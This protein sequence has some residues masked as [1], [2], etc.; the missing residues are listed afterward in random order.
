MLWIFGAP[1][2]RIILTLLAVCSL[3]ACSFSVPSRDEQSKL[4]QDKVIAGAPVWFANAG[5]GTGAVAQNGIIPST[6]QPLPSLEGRTVDVQYPMLVRAE[7]ISKA[8]ETKPVVT[9]KSALDRIAEQCSGSENEVN[10]AL[11][12]VD[13]DAKIKQYEALTKKCP[14]SADLQLWLSNEY[15]KANKLVAARTGYGQV[16]VLDPTNEDAKI[17]ISKVEKALS[18]QQ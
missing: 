8:Q 1:L 9:P 4:V 17:G 7:E 16:L 5:A 12:N 11:T 3:T 14:N 6:V 18:E 2:M 15:L 10:A 13:R